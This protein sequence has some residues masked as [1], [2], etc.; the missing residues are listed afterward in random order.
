[1]R[2]AAEL[3]Y[4]QLRSLWERFNAVAKDVL[5]IVPG[6]YTSSQLGLLLGLAQ[7][8]AMPVRAMLD[9]AAAASSRPYPGRQLVYVDA[10]LHR[11][12]VRPLR[13]DHEATALA[14]LALESAGLAALN[15]LFTKRIAELFVLGTRYD[16]FHRADSEQ[17]LYDRLPGWLQQL[18]NEPK[19]ELTLPFGDDELTVDL[20][21][22]QLL[23]AAGGF[24]KA[25]LQLIAQTREPGASLVVQ[26]SERVARQPGLRSELARLD[27]NLY[28][29]H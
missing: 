13:Q 26:L 18:Q 16:P 29:S 25:L 5:L 10:G 17:A 7:E 1:V 20:E 14:E 12:T 6:H 8:C 21:R 15:D 2:S 11:T 27:A 22:S 9:V 23:A 24:Y 19:I 28:A 4:A 3:A